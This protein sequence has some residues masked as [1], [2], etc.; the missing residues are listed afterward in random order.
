MLL[1]YVMHSE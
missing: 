1:Q